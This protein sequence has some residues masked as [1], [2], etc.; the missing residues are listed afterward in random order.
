MS[1]LL[2]GWFSEKAMA[3]NELVDW[4][5]RD[6]FQLIENQIQKLAQFV[7]ANRING[8]PAYFYSGYGFTILSESTTEA[9]CLGWVTSNHGHPHPEPK[10]AQHK[11]PKD[12]PHQTKTVPTPPESPLTAPGQGRWVLVI[13]DMP[14]ADIITRQLLEMFGY[15]VITARNGTDGVTCFI[16]NQHKISLVITDL[17]LPG[18]DGPSAA[19]L[20]R[21]IK[22]HVKIIALSGYAD[23]KLREKAAKAGITRILEKPCKMNV[24]LDA[25][26][27]ELG[28]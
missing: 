26:K 20:I 23:S 16:Q 3:A 27:E 22:P 9:P 15:Q 4:S 7:C 24:L 19:T 8:I 17:I 13:D 28:D 5:L 18:M 12:E 11:H 14:S 2:P 25:I 10:H 21:R 6:W 1:T